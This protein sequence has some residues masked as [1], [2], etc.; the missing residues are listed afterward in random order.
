[1]FTVGVDGTFHRIDNTREFDLHTHTHNQRCTKPPR[2]HVPHY[3]VPLVEFGRKVE[4]WASSDLDGDG[5]ADLLMLQIN[6]LVVFPSSNRDP[7]EWPSVNNS[8]TLDKWD[9]DKC[10][11]H[12]LA[13]ADFDLDG[14]AE[15]LVVCTHPGENRLYTRRQQGLAGWNVTSPLG[16]GIVRSSALKHKGHMP[17]NATSLGSLKPQNKGVSVADIVSSTAALA[18]RPAL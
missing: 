8:V 14:D 18:S 1:M 12:S 6:A 5:L 13:V 16:Y 7:G 9:G 3:T 2:T 11:G 17:P 4:E 10:R 15:L